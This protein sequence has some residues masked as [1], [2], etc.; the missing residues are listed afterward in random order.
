MLANKRKEI[1]SLDDTDD[2]NPSSAPRY[3]NT[4]GHRQTTHILRVPQH[5][6]QPRACHA[7]KCRLLRA[8]E[9][10][11]RTMFCTN[12][13]N[14]CSGCHAELIRQRRTKQIETEILTASSPN[15]IL[16]PILNHIFNPTSLKHVQNL[17]QHLRS[18]IW[19]C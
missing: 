3:N 1:D 4:Q 13:Q 14:M 2:T 8:K 10:L 6:D 11:T 17:L 15:A 16:A 18:S 12:N 7:T 19:G 9:M 5:I